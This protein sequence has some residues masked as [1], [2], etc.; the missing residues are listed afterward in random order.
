MSCRRFQNK[1]NHTI[2]THMLSVLI[3]D[4]N[5]HPSY[6]QYPMRHHR[7]QWFTTSCKVAY[8]GSFQSIVYCVFIYLSGVNDRYALLTYGFFLHPDAVLNWIK[9]DVRLCCFP[10][11]FSTVY[12]KNSTPRRETV[13]YYCG[14]RVHTRA[15]AHSKYNSDL[16]TLLGTLDRAQKENSSVGWRGRAVAAVEGDGGKPNGNNRYEQFCADTH[17]RAAVV[18]LW[19]RRGY[20]REY[21]IILYV[22]IRRGGGGTSVQ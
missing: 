22:Y 16:P 12:R 11:R 10:T 19:C 21:I 8:R 13:T 6:C 17:R 15:D 2:L 14:E 9:F 4:T 5:I 20:R 1:N 3:Y 18:P 7:F